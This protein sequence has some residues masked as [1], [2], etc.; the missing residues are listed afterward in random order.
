M[1]I[2]EDEMSIPN[3]KILTQ[4]MNIKFKQKQL[5]KHY[6]TMQVG[7]VVDLMF[8]PRTILEL[9]DLLSYFQKNNISYFVFGK[10]SNVV[11]ND[12]GLEVIVINTEYLN[13]IYMDLENPCIIH[14]ECGASLAEISQ[15]ALNCGLSGLE[16]ASGI[17]GSVGGAVFM[18]AGAY[19]GEI[20]DVLSHSLIFSTHLEELSNQEHQFSYRKSILSDNNATICRASFHLKPCDKNIIQQSITDL[21]MQRNSKQPLELPSSGSTFKRPEGYFVGKL[22]TDAGL[23][24]FQLG[25]AMVST[26]HAGFIV[27]TNNATAQDILDL[28]AHIQQIIYTQFHVKL[29]PEVKFL[30]KNGTFRTLSMLN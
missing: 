21:E 18:N 27:N 15:F 11:V 1:I 19:G 7:G 8:F 22:I 12:E 2:I 6:T 13:N 25:G 26:K 16:F 14:A 20:K 29:E 24:G 30:E 23:K 10:G 9:Q 17:P 4:F 28:I 3:K 5:M